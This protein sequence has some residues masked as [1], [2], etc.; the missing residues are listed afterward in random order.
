MFAR[1]D[2]DGS[3]GLTAGELSESK[4][5][6]RLIEA[7]SSIDLDGDGALTSEELKTGFE[8]SSAGNGDRP[9][10]PPPPPQSEADAE[11]L[12]SSLLDSTDESGLSLDLESI[13][14]TLYADSQALF[15]AT[16]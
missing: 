1:M 8:A 4:G 10:P 16:A 5:G 12:F 2:A 6:E 9:P 3:G 15:G 11:S 13:A 7:F 14:E